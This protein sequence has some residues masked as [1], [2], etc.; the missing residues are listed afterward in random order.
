MS[1]RVVQVKPLLGRLRRRGISPHFGSVAALRLPAVLPV[2]A[3]CNVSAAV[4]LAQR[5]N[6]QGTTPAWP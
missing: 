5:G 1:S 2:R 6:A 3:H 4:G